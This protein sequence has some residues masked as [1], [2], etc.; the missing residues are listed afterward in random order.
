MEARTELEQRADPSAGR[1]TPGGRP[2][3][4]GDQ[5]EER[6]LPGAVPSHEPDGLPGGDRDGDVPERPDLLRTRPAAR[7]DELLERVRVAC[8]DD[9]PARDAVDR[10]LACAHLPSLRRD[11]GELAPHD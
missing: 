7:D 10:D 5:T 8:S 9:E 4:P 11:R 2:D 6:R 1:D 3:D